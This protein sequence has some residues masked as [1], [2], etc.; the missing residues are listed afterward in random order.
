MPDNARKRPDYENDAFAQKQQG[1]ADDPLAELARLIGQSDP[2][3]EQGGSRKAA[4]TLRADNRAAP[5]WLS[6]PAQNYD[7]H[8]QQDYRAGGYQQPDHYADDP[9]RY[10]QSQ[11]D[12]SQ[13]D[14]SQY[15]QS[16][17]QQP[18]SAR[19]F[20]SLFPGAGRD[21]HA[22]HDD[23]RYAD[24]GGYQDQ[25]YQTQGY[26]PDGRYHVAPPPA[27]EYDPDS[28]YADDGHM[29]PG[30]DYAPQGG[31][32]RNALL[33][34]AAVVGLAVVGTAGAFGYR[35]F[36]NGS[37]P[38]NP[39]VIKADPAPAKIVPAQPQLASASDKPFQER[40]GA[41]ATAPE[42]VVPREEQP[43]SLPVQPQR[44]AAPAASSAAPQTVTTPLP[45]AQPITAAE[46]KRVKTLTIRPDGAETA[47]AFPPPPGTQAA[48][49]ARAPAGK[50]QGNSAP[51][52]LAPPPPDRTKVASR[53]PSSQGAAS[54]SYVVQVSAQRTE[55][56]AHSSYRS[57]Q[58]K[59]PSV[60]S[61]REANI[62]RV[63]LGDKGGI[64]YRAQ[65]GAFATQDQA[66]AFCN[67]L[68]E[69]GGQCIVQRN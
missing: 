22:A 12:Q 65:V 23:Q 59:Y 69:A 49:P 48:P 15:D 11:Y 7:D 3:T 51:I 39:P 56:E 2:F 44:A 58:A 33:L 47:S 32:R 42:R 29:P 37:G 30:E 46:P 13:Y 53:T 43:V 24:H 17:G 9:S 19:P 52:Q 50:Q 64:Y 18:Q 25:D 41:S 67:S 54:G 8:Q 31:G 10:D 68:K 38:A 35:A 6:R 34:V 1:P 61:G 57:L 26:Q 55:A 40:I 20:P 16:H 62:R 21:T 4:P 66:S 27:G 5:E 14:Q 45:P 28:Y 63:D 36:T 60:L